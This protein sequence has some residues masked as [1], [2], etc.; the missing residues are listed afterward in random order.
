M[1]IQENVLRHRYCYCSKDGFICKTS[2]AVDNEIYISSKYSFLC[3][4]AEAVSHTNR[5]ALT[6]RHGTYIACCVYNFR[7]D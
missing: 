4:L 1:V 7:R 2:F 5:H 3:V 6:C